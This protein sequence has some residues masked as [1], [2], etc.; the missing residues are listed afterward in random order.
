[1]VGNT[2]DLIDAKESHTINRSDNNDDDEIGMCTQPNSVP[3]VSRPMSDDYTRQVEGQPTEPDEFDQNAP[4][5][6]VIF[7][8]DE[9]K[10]GN[11]KVNYFTQVLR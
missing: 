3:H 5:T 4:K 1:M 11:K 6:A 9:K 10:M 8:V 2:K 7:M